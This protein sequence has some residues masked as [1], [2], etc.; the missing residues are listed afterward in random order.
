MFSVYCYYASAVLTSPRFSGASLLALGFCSLAWSIP[1]AAS[2]QASSGIPS[3]GRFASDIEA[4][5]IHVLLILL[6]SGNLKAQS[7]NIHKIQIL[8]L[9]L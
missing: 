8:N 3:D 4:D 9:P 6:H 5:P 1:P 7:V 2:E